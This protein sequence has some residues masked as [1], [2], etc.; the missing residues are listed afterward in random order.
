M[1]KT[2]KRLAASIAATADEIG[3]ATSNDGDSIFAAETA[4]LLRDAQRLMNQANDR[5]TQGEHHEAD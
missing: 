3:K 4:I 5:M 1:T 2:I